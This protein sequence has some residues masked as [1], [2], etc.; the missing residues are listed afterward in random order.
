MIEEYYKTIYPDED[1]RNYMWDNDALTLYGERKIQ[2]FNIHTG[3][4][5]NSK[6]TKIIMMKS[7][8]GDY[9]VELNSETFTKPP[10]SANATSEL[11][12]AK[13]KRLVFFNEPENDAENKLQV[14]LLKKIADGYTATLK[15]RGL[16]L[17]MTDFPIFFRV[18]GACN[19]KP[20]LSSVDGGI[21]RRIRII[22]YPVKFI[23]EPDPNNKHQALLNPKMASILASTDVRNTYIRM[24]IDR[25]IN[26]T[27]KLTK[28]VIPNQITKDSNEYIQDCNEVLGFIMDGYEITNNEED[29]IQSSAIFASFKSKTNSKMLS[30]KFKDDICNI[31]GISYKAMTKGRFFIGLKEKVEAIDE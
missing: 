8:I 29:K 3:S 28:E 4:G 16:Y 15:A 2:S 18:E 24:L 9:F 25:F 19:N 12:E 26:V 13:G 31:S 30:S 5:S 17:S 27:S 22:N 10:R 23:S 11:Y 14:G 7:A 21:G 1:V 6:S 20:T